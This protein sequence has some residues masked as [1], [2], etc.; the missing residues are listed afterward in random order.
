MEN[1]IK[2]SVHSFVVEKDI[3]EENRIIPFVASAYTVDRDGDLIDIESMNIDEFLRNPVVNYAHDIHSHSATPIGKGVKIERTKKFLKIWVQFVPPEIDPFAEK[4][5]QLVKNKFLNAVSIGFI[6]DYSNVIN[7]DSMAIGGKTVSRLYNNVELYEL[8][9]V[10]VGSNRDA[11]R[12]DKGLL[13]NKDNSGQLE[14]GTLIKRIEA[15]ETKLNQT[16]ESIEDRSD[17]MTKYYAGLLEPV[18]SDDHTAADQ[19]DTGMIDGLLEDIDNN[20]DS[21]FE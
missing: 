2:K 20:I 11:L 3:D 16:T 7:P 5:Y 6:P 17:D 13:M 15:L 21:L 4:I 12:I 9:V 19:D 10:C 18:G 8:S 14:I 1:E